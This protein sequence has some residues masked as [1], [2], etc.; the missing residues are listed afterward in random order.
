MSDR[1]FYTGE[2]AFRW[3]HTE[4]HGVKRANE[5]TCDISGPH[6]SFEL[7]GCLFVFRQRDELAHTAGG[8]VV[9][10]YFMRTPSILVE[11]HGFHPAPDFC[12][13]TIRR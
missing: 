13:K 12:N 7:A 2:A 4:L 6:F 9:A 5:E 11:F 1:S 8:L 10:A 3:H